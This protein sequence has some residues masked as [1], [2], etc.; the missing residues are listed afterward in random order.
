MAKYM[1]KV[2]GAWLGGL[3]DS[4]KLVARAA[5][6]AYA[7]VFSSDEKQRNLWKIYEQSILDYS[8]T[9]LFE[10]TPDTLSDERSTS[11]DDAQAKYS[12]VVGTTLLTITNA[13][14]NVHEFKNTLI[15]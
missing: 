7:K 4:D 3:Y 5:Y 9:A 15:F 2:V 11:L 14:G 1:P 12:R 8:K 6:D 10:E 13:I